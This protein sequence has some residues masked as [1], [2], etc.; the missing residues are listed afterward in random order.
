MKI[1]KPKLWG[2]FAFIINIIISFSV[3]IFGTFKLP[4]SFDNKKILVSLVLI[5]ITSFI[6]I[7]IFC[8]IIY[9]F[10]MYL[11]CKKQDGYIS[12]LKRNIAG[13]NEERKNINDELNKRYEIIKNLKN[14]AND[15]LIILDDTIKYLEIGMLSKTKN[16][17]KFLTKLHEVVINK[18]NYIKKEESIHER[19]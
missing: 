14:Y 16:E 9:S 8:I 7:F 2:K 19:T 1:S 11:Y 4:D 6:I 12:E 10:Q 3:S 13:L 15:V 18:Y 5:F 17:Q